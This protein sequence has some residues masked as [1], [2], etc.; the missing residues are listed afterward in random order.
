VE[1]EIPLLKVVRDQAVLA[2]MVGTGLRRSE[3]A[4]LT[5]EMVQQRDGRWAMPVCRWFSYAIGAVCL[6]FAVAVFWLPILAPG[7]G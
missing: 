1:K 2:V 4:A 5:W 6:M 3:V 7:L